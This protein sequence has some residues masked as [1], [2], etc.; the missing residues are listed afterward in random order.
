[1][2][3]TKSAVPIVENTGSPMM[4][5]RER[6]SDF[7]NVQ[8]LPPVKFVD[9]IES[10]VLHQVPDPVRDDD[11][12]KCRD[13]SE[14]SPVQMIKMGVRDENKVYRGQMI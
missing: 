4:A 10:Q 12:L 13:P 8:R 11:G 9:P 6:D 3:S 1:M 7:S 5:G 14:S 2:K